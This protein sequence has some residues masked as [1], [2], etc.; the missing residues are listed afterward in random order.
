VMDALRAPK[1][2]RTTSNGS[3]VLDADPLPGGRELA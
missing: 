2:G 1:V 3:F